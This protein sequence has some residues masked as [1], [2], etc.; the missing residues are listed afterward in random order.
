MNKLDG[1]PFNSSDV[2]MLTSFLDIVGATMSTSQMFNNLNSKKSAV[3]EFEKLS[4]A[5]P[6][7]LSAESKPALES[8]IE[9]GDEEEEDSEEEEEGK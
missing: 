2:D 8:F 6:R 3:S 5:T 9:E 7:R 1:Q 4:T